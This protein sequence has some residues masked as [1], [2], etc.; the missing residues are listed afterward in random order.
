MVVVV[1]AAERGAGGNGGSDS[2]TSHERV[3]AERR[4]RRAQHGPWGRCAPPCTGVRHCFSREP[5]PVL[6]PYFFPGSLL[7]VR[8]FSSC[9][10]PLSFGPLSAMSLSPQL[11]HTLEG[12]KYQIKDAFWALSSCICQQ[13]AKVKINGRTCAYH[14]L[15]R[16]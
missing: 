8:P 7:H 1:V 13:S 3:D 9:L 6:P 12:L 14:L 11:M 10:H 4:L 5:E 2:R 15:R 16:M